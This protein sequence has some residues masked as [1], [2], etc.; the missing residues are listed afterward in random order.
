MS[1]CRHELGGGGQLPNPPAIPTLKSPVSQLRLQL[2]ANQLRIIIHL[3]LPLSWFNTSDASCYRVD[4]HLQTA[5]VVACLFS[6]T[7]ND[8]E[9]AYRRK[10][11]LSR[12]TVHSHSLIHSFTHSLMVLRTCSVDKI[13]TKLQATD[14]PASSTPAR[15][16]A[17][18]MNN[19]ALQLLQ[20]LHLQL[21]QV[22]LQK[23]QSWLDLGVELKSR[24]KSTW[25]SGVGSGRLYLGSESNFNGVV[26]FFFKSNLVHF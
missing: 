14:K 12:E 17:D 7:L 22:D 10:C 26:W 15:P 25:G 20:R 18:W 3:T 21:L 1:V 19:W 6:I 8:W 2:A 9:T 4:N 13:T 23:H 11:T 5:T 24:L 16:T